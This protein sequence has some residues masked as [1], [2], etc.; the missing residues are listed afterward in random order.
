MIYDECNDKDDLTGRKNA[1]YDI[2]SEKDDKNFTALLK[3]WRSQVVISNFLTARPGPKKGG[4]F[5]GRP[6]KKT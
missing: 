3:S 5:G 1:R 6:T 2:V 4:V